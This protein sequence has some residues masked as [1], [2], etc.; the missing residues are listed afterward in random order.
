MTY[1]HTDGRTTLVVKSLSRLKTK[2]QSLK[3]RRILRKQRKINVFM[4][5]TENRKKHTKHEIGFKP[6]YFFLKRWNNAF[7]PFKYIIITLVLDFLLQLLT[8]A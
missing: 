7:E 2:K 3:Q 4:N 8:K 1:A 6:I 5:Y